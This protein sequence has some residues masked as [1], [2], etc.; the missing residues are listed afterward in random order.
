MT[1]F[2]DK[3]LPY[4]DTL[5]KKYIVNLEKLADLLERQV[6][7]PRF[8]MGHYL[9]NAKLSIYQDYNSDLTKK[10]AVNKRT[11]NHCG[12]SACA[13]GHG[14]LAGIRKYH[15]ENWDQYS[16]RVFG[17]DSYGTDWDYLFDGS[18]SRTDNTPNGA[19][20]RIRFLLAEGLPDDA[21]RQRL[22][23]AKLTYTKYLKAPVAFA[24]SELKINKEI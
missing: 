12:T 6:P 14:P 22:G 13:V 11:Y 18:W 1:A 23:H 2:R 20:A 10:G 17:I 5:K 8:E 3:K 4:R 21:Y 16:S 19:A 15:T 24:P 7:P 9:E